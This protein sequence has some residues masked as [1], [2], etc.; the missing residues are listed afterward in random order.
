M[1][2]LA[3]RLD[4]AFADAEIAAVV[5]LGFAALKTYVPAPET[6]RGHCVEQIR[7][8]GKYLV[9]ELDGRAIRVRKHGTE[10]KA[11]WW[12]LAPGDDGPLERL[13]RGYTGHVLHRAHV[14]PHVSPYATPT[15]PRSRRHSTRSASAPVGSRSRSSGLA[16][17][18]TI[19]MARGAPSAARSCAESGTSPLRSRTAPGSRPVARC[20]P[21]AASPAWSSRSESGEMEHPRLA[22]GAS[23]AGVS[24]NLQRQPSDVRAVTAEVST[25]L[26][27]R[28]GVV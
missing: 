28:Q 24:A 8:R 4:A 26:R 10:R 27:Y 17:A 1:Q 11:A 13:G 14:S 22:A 9:V 16:F 23:V 18:S 25:R 15:P 7:R 6:T 12:V 21:T 20:W 19:V 2:A 5:P 3:E